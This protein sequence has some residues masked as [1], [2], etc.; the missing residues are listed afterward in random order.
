[1]VAGDDIPDNISDVKNI[2]GFDMLN[3]SKQEEIEAKFREQKKVTT[4]VVYKRVGI[5]L[6]FKKRIL[7]FT[8][9]QE[10]A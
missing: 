3:K 4:F 10:W 8:L 2:E 5:S 9:L 1:M 6:N 7:H